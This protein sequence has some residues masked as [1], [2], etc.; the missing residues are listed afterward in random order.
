VGDDA[1]SD[2]SSQL[3][4]AKDLADV[5]EVVK[6]A[7]E[8]T[9]GERRA[10]LMLGLADLPLSLGAFYVVGS[11]IIVM[12]RNLYNRILVE[13]PNMVNA[14][15]FRILLHE[16]LHSMGYLNEREVRRLV[17]EVS[18]S[19]LGAH[20]PATRIS[21]RRIQYYF[22]H[23]QYMPHRRWRGRRRLSDLEITVVKG[24]DRSSTVY[25]A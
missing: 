21:W 19:A 20:H 2:L 8:R 23:T 7:A 22:P 16:Y 17:S 3:A 24:F 25:I 14:F 12:N 13:H 18:H 1:L 10:G 4:Y 6:K 15:S 11:N 5:F 9:L